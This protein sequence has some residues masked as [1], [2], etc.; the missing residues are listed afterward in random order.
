MNIRI[1]LEGLRFAKEY[2]EANQDNDDYKE[3]FNKAMDAINDEIELLN[4]KIVKQ[5]NKEQ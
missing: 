4:N 1:K 3:L 5:I 2:I